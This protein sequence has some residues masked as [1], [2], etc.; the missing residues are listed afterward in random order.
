MNESHATDA[1][2]I[3][4]SQTPCVVCVN[5]LLSSPHYHPAGL[6]VN[7]VNRCAQLSMVADTFHYAPLPWWARLIIVIAFLFMLSSIPISSGFF[8]SLLLTFVILKCL[9][10]NTVRDLKAL[11]LSNYLLIFSGLIVSQDLWMVVYLFVAVFANL[12][13]MIKL[14]A[15]EV[16][17]S[18]ISSKS[19]MQLLII[20]PLSILLFYVFPR[21]DPLW[22]IP[23]VTKL[24]ASL[25]EKMNAGSIVGMFGDDSTA[26]QI[27]FAKQPILRGYWRGI[28]LSFY[29]GKPGIRPAQMLA[30]SNYYLHSIKI[31]RQIMRYCW[32]P[33]KSV[34]CI[35]KVFWQH[36]NRPYYFHRI[37][38][39]LYQ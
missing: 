12:S 1:A 16:P 33:H 30:K 29:N 32:S 5:D 17:L 23:T 35:M 21:L 14:S 39:Y 19:G 20:I 10:L 8:I 36:Q 11:I 34:F 7:H 26:M 38:D 18:Q 27:T 28:L 9:E 6:V 13:L 37:S 22:R 4:K 2:A 31:K 24:N 15:P 3:I 25:E